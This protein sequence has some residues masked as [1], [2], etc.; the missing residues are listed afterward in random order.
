ML[1]HYIMHFPGE[2]AFIQKM[3]GVKKQLEQRGGTYIS[4]FCTPYQQS[5]LTSMF[6]GSFHVT[7]MG[8]FDE[9]ER[10][11]A[12]IS[13]EELIEDHLSIVELSFH[14]KFGVVRHQDILGAI[15][16]LGI[17]RDLIGDIVVG[18]QIF[19]V[20][21]KSIEAFILSELKQ[22]GRVHVR[23][24]P[25]YSVVYEQKPLESIKIIVSSYRVD[26]IVSEVYRVKRPD[27]QRLIERGDVKVNHR[28]ITDDAMLLSVHD[29]IAVKHYG[30]FKLV[31]VEGF[32]KKERIVLLIE[33][34]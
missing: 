10:K 28:V 3:M 27:V 5:I 32:T 17:E 11:I 15:L 23:L 22:V 34:Y 2:D 25:V 1:N 30:R 24:H 7:F 4:K 21:Q 19:I 16:A 29:L 18:E 8:G 20:M 9:A 31:S 13:E 12:L 33:V 14:K 26:K 6:N